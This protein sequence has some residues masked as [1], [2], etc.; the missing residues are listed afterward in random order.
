[1]K[2]LVDLAKKNFGS[3]MN[4]VRDMVQ[5]VFTGL[6]GQNREHEKMATLQKP[7]E[8]SKIRFQIL[9]RHDKIC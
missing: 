4:G 8:I 2:K 9:I 1:M 5:C 3:R 6:P 7:F